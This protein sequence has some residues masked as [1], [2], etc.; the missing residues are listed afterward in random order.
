MS[1]TFD[2]ENE[3][4]WMAYLDGQM[5]ASEASAFDAGLSPEMQERL[6]AEM[7]LE[8][9]LAERLCGDTQCPEALWK[10]LQLEMNNGPARR[11]RLPF[12]FAAAAAVCLVVGAAWSGGVLPRVF[13]G[14]SDNIAEAGPVLAIPDETLEAYASHA[15]TAATRESIERF[16]LDNNIHLALND[17]HAMHPDS[18]HDVK[19]VGACTGKCKEK[20]LYEVMFTCC[21]QP[22]KIA[23]AKQGTSGAEMIA[24]SRKCHEVQESVVMGEYVVAV[25]G[26]H[27][28]PD[29][30][31]I[32]KPR[33]DAI[34]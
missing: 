15:E 16:L 21:G 18:R 6:A 25:I 9:G 13:P 19:L 23:I 27:P 10:R 5:T 28:A 11:R 31:D 14:F 1:G 8:A 33:P 30:I 3:A 22:V 2:N 29:L 26:K 7:R 24:K 20:T 17:V 4:L 32:L 12:T 34:V